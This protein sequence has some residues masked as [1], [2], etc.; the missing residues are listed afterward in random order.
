MKRNITAYTVQSTHTMDNNDNYDY[1]I[2]RDQAAGYQ[3]QQ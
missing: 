2:R 1:K 3:Q